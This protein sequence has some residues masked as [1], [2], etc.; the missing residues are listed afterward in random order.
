MQISSCFSYAGTG[1]AV[2]R[3]L[4]AC[5]SVVALTC[6]AKAPSRV[7]ITTQPDGAK[8][9]VDGESRGTAPVQVFGL[10]QGKHLFHVEAPGYCTVD[11]YVKV[12]GEGTLLQKNFDLTAEKA[13]IFVQSEPAGAE[14]KNQGVSLGQTPVFISTLATGRPYTFEL[15]RAGYR[16]V[17]VA[18]NPEGRTPLTVS[19][20]LPIDSGVLECISEPA[21]AEVVV[22]GVARGVTPV[23]VEN[24]PKG[25]ASVSFRLKG[26]RGETRQVVVSP[27]GR[28]QT[29]N[30]KLTGL[31]ATLKVVSE[32]EGARVF[33]DGDYQGKTPTSAPQL[34]AGRHTVRVELNGFADQ[35]REVTVENGGES[36]ET[37]KLESVL[38]RLEVITVPPGAKVSID[39]K[40]VGTTKAIAGQAKS[41]VLAL[42]KI[43]AGERSV[44]VS[45]PGCQEVAR[46]V[47]VPPKGTA[48]QTFVLKSLFVPDTEIETVQGTTRRGVLKGDG[49][50]LDGVHLEI[51]PGVEQ[52]FPH[53]SVRRI[54]S[55][56]R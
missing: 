38:G 24:V 35:E 30:V 11:E 14:V 27:D 36:T 46:K 33:V 15:V 45:A 5:V 1:K 44:V 39:G 12:G 28:S 31:P 29:V 26:F 52:V 41:A 42:E 9:F 32:P 34:A 56:R 37:F 4:V 43:S 2:R 10:S 49:K 16:T 6:L 8:V 17:K 19:E 22:N 23:V 53:D 55:L 21:G 3:T 7:D 40:A 13:L 48:Q 50:D 18:V 20:K 51:S 25:N 47:K 54:R